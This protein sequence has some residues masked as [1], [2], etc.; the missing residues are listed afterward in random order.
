MLGVTF[1]YLLGI[2]FQIKQPVKESSFFLFYCMVLFPYVKCR[3][4]FDVTSNSLTTAL[5]VFFFFFFFQ[6]R[7]FG[8]FGSE[9]HSER[10]R[11]RTC[12]ISFNLKC[13]GMGVGSPTWSYPRIIRG[14]TLK[15]TFMFNVRLVSLGEN[16][17]SD[18][19][20]VINIFT[21]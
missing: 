10:G 14:N 2:N 20:L 19:E 18:S 13:E 16:Y 5:L 7:V 12:L 9:A 21:S 6:N 17:F 15:D 11:G 3:I 1:E 4:S 8:G